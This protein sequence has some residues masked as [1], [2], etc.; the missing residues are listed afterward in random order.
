MDASAPYPA[1]SNRANR[2]CKV[3]TNVSTP[4][5]TW[6]CNTRGST[7]RLEF[8]V[9]I[10]L[11]VTTFDRALVEHKGSTCILVLW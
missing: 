1:N 9:N 2:G 3:M 10:E 4:G 11:I 7:S 8:V 5:R 6:A